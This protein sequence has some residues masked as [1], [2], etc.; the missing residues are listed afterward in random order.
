MKWSRAVHH[1][2]SLARTCAEMA[3]RPSSIFPLRVVQLW[4]TGEVLGTP[5]ELDVVTVALSVDLPVEDVPWR[6][7]PPGAQHWANATRLD[8]SPVIARWRSVHAPI[9]N[10]EIR[11]PVLLW[12][13]T[14]GVAEDAI[15]ALREGHGDKVGLAEPTPE[16]LRARVDD[17]LAVSL[18]SLRER[19]RDYEERRW[20]PGK[21]GPIADAL[22]QAG[23]GYLDLL[24]AMPD[25]AP[26]PG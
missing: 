9:W 10:H 8:R 20:R 1:V 15:A 17:E 6:S 18:R 24:D 22:W 11:R 4:A 19:T 23:D 5:R 16:L 26:D 25:L 13:S 14:D 21:L 7:D 12:D 3:T 2:E